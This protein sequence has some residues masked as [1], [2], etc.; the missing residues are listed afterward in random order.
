MDLSSF[1]LKQQ[2][3]CLN[4]SDHHNIGHA[5]NKGSEYLESDV[6]EQVRYIFSLS[7]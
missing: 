2:T 7:F 5:L 4:E 1:L 3:E 6:D